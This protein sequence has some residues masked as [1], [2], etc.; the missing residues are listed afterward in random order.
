MISSKYTIREQ[1]E[2]KILNQIIRYKE[3]SR[4]ELS[5]ITSLNKASVSSIINKLIDDSL[6]IENRI[7]EATNRGRKPIMLTFNGVSSGL[8]IAIDL[9]YNYI[10]G[11]V[12]SLDGKEIAR[13][14]LTD[15][16]VSKDNIQMLIRKIIKK[17]TDNLPYTRHG[18]IGMTIA[19]Q[20][21]VLNNKVLSTTYNGL[22]EIDLVKLLNQEYSFPVF[23]QNEANLSALGEYTFSSDIENLVSISLH[24]GIGVGVVKNGKLDIGNKGYAGQLGHT[25]LFPNGRKCECGNYGC[26]EKYCSTQVIY[27]EISKE[28]KLDKINSDIVEYLY[29]NKDQKVV[30]MIELYAYYLSI[31]INNI[32]MLYAPELVIFNSPLTKK[33]PNIINII[34]NFL[35]NQYTKEIHIINSPIEWNPV[36]S[37]A[38]SF[39]IQKFLNIEKLKLSSY[40]K[41]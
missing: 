11:M 25:I 21:Q 9:G 4:A 17:L 39:S 2:A 29:S 3:I 40:A 30:E 22:E 8:A 20:G 28:K 31:G 34:K 32:V 13:I 38:I 19:V 35:N 5:K 41:N 7:G 23:L 14:Q 33:I 18:I 6:V 15:T 37:G 36:L 16:Y 12:A 26:L 1:N 10:D 24:S 27:Q